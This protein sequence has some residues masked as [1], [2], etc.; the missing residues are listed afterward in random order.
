MK[1]ETRAHNDRYSVEQI[2]CLFFER[3][4][5]ITIISEYDE[6]CKKI[7]TTVKAEEKSTSASYEADISCVKSF[8]NSVKKSAYLAMSELSNRNT[9]WGI[10]T[11]IR[12]TKF[13]RDLHKQYSYDEIR[14]LL[15]DD[16]WVN[17]EKANFCTE[18]AE[19]SEKLIKR[20]EPLTFGL[21]LGVPFC[22]S[23]CSYCSFVSESAALYSKYIPEYTEALMK[24][25]K[26]V[27]KLSA[28][29]GHKVSS[30]YFGGGTPPTLGVK[31]LRD[32]IECVWENFEFS[33]K[34]PEFTVEAGRPDIINEELVRTLRISGVNRIC[35]NPQ[36]MND[37]TLKLIGRNHSSECTVRAFDFA[38]KAGFEN[39]NSD[40]IAGL[41][42]ENIDMFL[43]T[44]EDIEKL[45]P[46]GIT[47]HT[48]Y[49][50]R[51]SKIT[52]E[53]LWEECGKDVEKMLEASAFFARKNAYIPYYMYK[54]RSTMGNL[55]NTGYAKKGYE[56]LYN[57]AIMEEVQT[58]FACGAGA[59]TKV[60]R[61]NDIQRIYN[62]KDAF[63]Y[64]R[65]IDFIIE[66][67]VSEIRSLLEK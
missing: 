27:A 11:G 30:V 51:T 9:P 48:M 23:R 3:D 46:E 39:I 60:V 2:S 58:I 66:N 43:K 16:Y 13:V 29:T 45:S 17:P 5:D 12:P 44:L 38:R 50:K 47:V 55:E 56:S 64:I 18:V 20:V 4:A 59:S 28:E 1:I 7:T 53:K 41:P 21:Y 67:K 26:A 8:K 65:D 33:D 52:K 32:I 63:S 57:S 36:T 54:Q 61:E 25:I 10:L 22:P 19:N 40:L 37:E 49:L 14:A 24:E 34:T 62:I 35:I 31:G 15:A 42:G 6:L